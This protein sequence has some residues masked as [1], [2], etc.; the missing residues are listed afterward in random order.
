[1]FALIYYATTTLLFFLIWR[2][3]KDA[4]AP[5][6]VDCSG[7]DYL[8]QLSTADPSMP[9]AKQDRDHSAGGEITP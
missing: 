8:D 1:M 4:F 7:V 9:E 6:S 5:P 2:S 3:W